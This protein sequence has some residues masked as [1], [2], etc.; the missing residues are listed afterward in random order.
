MSNI[1]PVD[2][3][4]VLKNVNFG[5]QTA[6]MKEEVAGV[7]NTV[8][9]EAAKMT[10][11]MGD[12]AENSA[13]QMKESIQIQK[14]VIKDLQQSI[15][16]LQNTYN[17]STGKNKTDAQ[18]A[19]GLARK[20]LV[21]EQG[22]LIQMQK[23]QVA[24]NETEAA[25]QLPI[26]GGL[27][28]WVAG[29]VTVAA[30]MEV[31]KKIIESTE[32]TAHKF[33]QGMAAATSATNYFF[34]A[35]ATGDWSNFWEGMDRAVTG[36]IDYV[37]AMEVLNNK[38]NEEEV[39]SSEIDIRIGKNRALTFDKDNTNNATRKKAYEDILTDSKLQFDAKVELAKQ[40][41][42][43]NL[44]KAASDSKLSKE[45]IEQFIKEYSS[46]EKMLKLGEEYNKLPV[47][48]VFTQGKIT[49]G[50]RRPDQ[51]RVDALG[52]GAKQAG[53]YVTQISRV[54]PETRKQL[55]GLE[56]TVNK[57]A[58]GFDM[59]NFRIKTGLAGL[60]SEIKDAAKKAQEEK[61][62]A[63]KAQ[64]DYETESG[65]ESIK[66]QIGIDQDKLN[67]QKD[68]AEKSRQQAE[69]DYRKTLV[70]LA[71]Q[72]ADQLKKLNETPAIG[73]IGKDGKPIA[74]K[75]VDKLPET[76]QKQLDDKAVL[77][78]AL[79]TKTIGDIN[80]KEAE[81]IKEI[82]QEVTDYRLR[83]ID[84]EK[85]AVKDHYDKLEAAAIKLK[86]TAA[87][88]AIIPLR[89]NAN[90]EI[91]NKYALQ[92]IDFEQKIETQK[93][94]IQATGFDREAKLMKLN[95]DTWVKYNNQRIALLKKSNDP[96]DKQE[97]QLLQGDIDI[98]NTEKK[99]RLQDQ[100]LES[101]R[102][103][104]GE[105]I[106]QLGLSDQES[107]LLQGMADITMDLI[108]GG[109]EGW[110]AAATTGMSML[111]NAFSGA[112][113]SDA[114]TKSLERTNQLLQQQAAI[115][116]NMPNA[117]PYF[118]LAAKQYTDYGTAI[119]LTN[120]KLQDSH[121]LTKNSIAEFKVIG[122]MKPAEYTG[123]DR[124]EIDKYKR[125]LE[126]YNKAYSDFFKKTTGS[127]KPDDFIKAF[128]EG[129]LV[130]DQ[131]EIDWITQMTEKQK[132]RAELLQE[133]FR[134]A[135]GF[136]ST[137]VSDSIMQGIQDGL[138]LADNGLGGFAQSFGDQVKKALVKGITDAMNLQLTEGFMTDFNKYMSD[139]A[140][141][142]D[143]R[144]V[145]EADYAKVISDGDAKWKALQ[146]IL[147]KYG[148]GSATTASAAKGISASATEET[149][150][151]M[152][153]QMMAV[154]VDIKSILATMAMGQ[155]DVAKN[156]MY[157]KQIVDNT[158]PIYRLKAIEEGI[159]DLNKNFKDKL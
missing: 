11:S 49:L 121:I 16:E 139:G 130:L 89:A 1:P 14:S 99:A 100:I 43:I 35:I 12:F 108:K 88:A 8:Q 54:L 117:Q 76:Q 93:N 142:E 136:D 123:T 41:H 114:T 127:Y 30:A 107:N 27:G 95:F 77:A 85:A 21:A 133:T 129:S 67:L 153:G 15:K 111:M 159:A 120:K 65:R 74:G 97:A 151:A 22:A 58:A 38:K 116:S 80:E 92:N 63:S 79:K 39:K 75:Y 34:Q 81:K 87:L 19:L 141:S 42:E 18:S 148:V 44:E 115:L 78:E 101:A 145:L 119:D 62:K 57:L 122:G 66:T 91:D 51:S 146:P 64:L 36:A 71:N 60:N 140:L 137:E 113:K 125:D 47:T 68:S 32:T 70:D 40:E 13:K 17:N 126:A 128:A 118:E 26:I 3:E 33:E 52:P 157:M 135:L 147:D 104:T 150:S 73:G 134:Q 109:P 131:Q 106:T 98:A 83:G 23:A 59:S 144:K 20:D 138:K 84:K 143:E 53:E 9:Q 61:D 158:A 24:A 149:T 72:K 94:Q 69:L 86:D 50:E 28:K 10:Q 29:L 82:W 90:T 48:T 45:R 56:A 2:I 7:T 96:K 6:K 25:S 152:V 5:Q 102:Q 132:Q 112:G 103:F 46:I 155:D 156:L 124:Y 154:R 37:N 105:L 110:I 31:G 55:S 4:F